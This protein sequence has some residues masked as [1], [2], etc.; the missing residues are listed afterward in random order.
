MYAI[1]SYYVCRDISKRLEEEEKLKDSERH[2]MF[3][4]QQ[5]PL[6]IIEWN[7]NFEV[8]QWNPAAEEIF[9]YSQEEAIGQHSSFIIDKEQEKRVELV[10]NNVLTTKKSTN[11]IN[12][13]K[14]KNGD[15]ILCEWHNTPLL[16]EN[17][18]TSY[19]VCYTKLLR[20]LLTT[21]TG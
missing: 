7:L 1:R 18:I 6:A 4:I 17:R 2:R 14:C 15:L 8:Q 9:G 3:H 16:D 12:K 20:V 19:N 13:N 5:S 21:E 11:S 10:W